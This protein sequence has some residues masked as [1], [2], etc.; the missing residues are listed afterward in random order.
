MGDVIELSLDERDRIWVSPAIQRRLGLLPGM[1]LIVEEGDEQGV[2]LRPEPESVT[3]VD[4]DGVWV[5]RAEAVDDLG[6]VVGHE[7]Q[8]RLESLL[9]GTGL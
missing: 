6:D 4:K 1:T 2:R 7:H 3:V 8:R 9:V 5:V